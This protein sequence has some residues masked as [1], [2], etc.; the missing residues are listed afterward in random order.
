MPRRNEDKGLEPYQEAKFEAFLGL[1]K[2][3]GAK[4]WTAIAKA[5]DV[6][7]NT[8][9]AWKRHP[10]AQQAIAD[11]VKRSL[12]QMEKVG[13]KDWRMWESKLKI[14]GVNPAQVVENKVKFDDPVRVLLAKF[15]LGQD[16][17]TKAKETEG[18]TSQSGS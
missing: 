10:E 14:L 7:P 17:V 8:I 11:E 18:T 13:T 12:E 5:L 1:I 4:N 3:D 6:H 2:N 16:N 9:T 15:E